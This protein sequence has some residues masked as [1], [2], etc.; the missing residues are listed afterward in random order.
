ML[1]TTPGTLR[2]TGGQLARIMDRG[3]FVKNG[4]RGPSDQMAVSFPQEA[5]VTKKALIVG[6]AFAVNGQGSFV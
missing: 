6:L 3:L 4:I 2:P 5:D 1:I